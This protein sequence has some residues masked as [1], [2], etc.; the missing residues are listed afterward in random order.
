MP[1]RVTHGRSLEAPSAQPDCDRGLGFVLGSAGMGF[2]EQC[3]SFP[4]SCAS[5]CKHLGSSGAAGCRFTRREIPAP[6]KRRLRARSVPAPP[7]R[8]VLCVFVCETDEMT[9]LQELK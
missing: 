7:C 5:L 2:G 6:V 8:A 9:Q 3:G 1:T 4:W